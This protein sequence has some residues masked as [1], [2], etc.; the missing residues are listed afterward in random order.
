MP[1]GEGDDLFRF[2]EANAKAENVPGLSSAERLRAALAAMVREPGG[3]EARPAAGVDVEANAPAFSII[4]SRKFLGVATGQTAVA[5][6]VSAVTE[7]AGWNAML[8][9]APATAATTLNTARNAAN[10]LKIQLSPVELG[11]VTATLKMS[12]GNLSIELQVETIEAYRQLSSDQ[13]SLVRALRG[14][15]YDIE[16]V[17]LHQP[18]SG[19]RGQT[20]S[21]TMATSNMQGGGGQPASSNGEGNQAGNGQQRGG[22]AGRD[23]QHHHQG[24]RRG[25]N[26][27]MAGERN[28][29]GGG[30]YL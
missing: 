9:E 27:G 30:V 17:V 28:R 29:P 23:G 19:E 4:E 2:A 21:A 24:E 13:H 18:P 11:T 14:H 22:E 16:Q 1:E 10:T 26:G 8:R 7:N 3:A 6:V 12:G 5:S 20:V 15:G 25:E